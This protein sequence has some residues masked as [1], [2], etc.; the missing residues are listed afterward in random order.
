MDEY[1]A[2][3]PLRTSSNFARFW[4][5]E[6]NIA[7]VFFQAETEKFVNEPCLN[8]S[9]RAERVSIERFLGSTFGK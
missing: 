2:F 7:N 8:V 5:T 3:H 1:G 9:R 6:S 4:M